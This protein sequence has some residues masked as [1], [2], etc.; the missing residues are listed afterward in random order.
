MLGAYG[1]LRVGMKVIADFHVHSRYS[2]ACSKTI[3]IKGLGAEAGGKG[4]NL[5][6][7]GDFTHPLWMEEIKESLVPGEEDGVF[8]VKGME[9][10]ASF[11]L[12]SEVSTIS[13]DSGK[14]RKVHHCILAS[15]IGPAESIN[16]GLKRYGNLRSDGRPTLL[17][18]PAELAGLVFDSDS[19]AF[20]F[21]A[22]IWT[23]YFGVLGSISGFDSIDEAY[24]DMAKRVYALE[25][26]LSSD[27]KM[28]WRVSSLDR[29]TLISNSDMHS[30]F[31]L[32]REANIFEMERPSYSRAIKAIKEK[33][34]AVFKGTIEFYPEEG[35][36]HNDGHRG[37]GF[38]ADPGK[39]KAEL[40]PVCGNPPV[41]G[42]MHR[43]NDLADRAP[44]FVPEGRPPYVNI[45]PLAEVISHAIGKGQYSSSVSA[46][47]G[48]LLRRFGTEFAVLMEADTETISKESERSIG[49]SIYNM[50]HK[51]VR[52]T[53]GYDGVYGRIDLLEAGNPPSIRKGKAV[54][55]Q[56]GL[57]EF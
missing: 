52:I 39:G 13:R 31:K 30:L 45:V 5:I 51:K 42:V 28:N 56:K 21:P 24:G 29:F 11:V 6:G 20:L 25:T 34:A 36:Y 55:N 8:K 7:T 40:C 53:A 37:C 33:D 46:I 41:I 47:Y 54:R 10:G 23:P 4:I 35:K 27:P 16:A 44:G 19:D 22:H 26:G 18:S 50:R 32:G 38:S 57:A 14:V 43:I 2:M 15:G 17:M 3:T 48:R 49:D 1:R 12:S 9:S